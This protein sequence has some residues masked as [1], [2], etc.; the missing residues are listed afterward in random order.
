MWPLQRLFARI[1][2]DLLRGRR[3]THALALVA[4]S[5]LPPLYEEEDVSY[6]QAHTDTRF[7]S[8]LDDPRD[9]EFLEVG[10]ADQSPR[11]VVASEF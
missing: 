11:S 3:W 1:R 5:R 7:L 4:R 2:R 6:L 9:E 10:R 8:M